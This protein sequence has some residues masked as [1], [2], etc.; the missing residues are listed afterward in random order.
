MLFFLQLLGWSVSESYHFLSKGTLF[1]GRAQ[2]ARGEQNKVFEKRNMSQ[3]V[4][5]KF[6]AVG[7]AGKVWQTSLNKI[8]FL[9]STHSMTALSAVAWVE[10]F[11]HGMMMNLSPSIDL[12]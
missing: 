7:F 12:S 1:L 6:W 9:I 8:L 2:H 5:I 10:V 11:P 3:E 4:K